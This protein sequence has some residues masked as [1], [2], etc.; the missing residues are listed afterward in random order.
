MRWRSRPTSWSK[1]ASSDGDARKKRSLPPVTL[2]GQSTILSSD[3]VSRLEETLPCPLRGYSWK[4]LYSL[5]QHGANLGTFYAR[6]QFDAQTLIVVQTQ[7][8]EIFGGFAS[9]TWRPSHCEYYGTGESYLF[10]VSN[11]DEDLTRK[12]GGPELVPVV[13]PVDHSG[14]DGPL[15][16]ARGTVV[17]AANGLPEKG[18]RGIAKYE[19]SGKNAYFQICTD[20]S[21]A[22]GGGGAF[23]LYIDDDLSKGSTGPSDTFANEPLCTTADFDVVNLE[24]WGFTTAQSTAALAKQDA[25]KMRKPRPVLRPTS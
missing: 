18:V 14:D 20:A 1:P 12:F 22:M 10:A 17:E 5:E 7:K 21:I 23:G 19:W 25:M 24:C 9:E 6:T 4:L 8:D 13:R 11:L 3:I 2:L 15:P 16:K